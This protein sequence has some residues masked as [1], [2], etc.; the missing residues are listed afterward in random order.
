MSGGVR[1]GSFEDDQLTRGLQN[2]DRNY[3]NRTDERE[4]RLDSNAT[5]IINYVLLCMIHA[6]LVSLRGRV[7]ARGLYAHGPI[8]AP[9]SAV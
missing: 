9:L 5:G 8:E 3:E 4:C 6:S 1:L 2:L 7:Y